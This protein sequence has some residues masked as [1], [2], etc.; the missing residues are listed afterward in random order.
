[1]VKGGRVGSRQPLN[2]TP[3]LEIGWGFCVF[4]PLPLPRSP[5][6]ISSI[7]DFTYTLLPSHLSQEGNRI[8]LMEN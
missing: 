8:L 7:A 1:A 6:L 3:S 4:R 5:V 2:Q